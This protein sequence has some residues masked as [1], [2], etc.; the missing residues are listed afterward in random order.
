MEIWRSCTISGDLEEVP[1]IGPAAV[2]ILSVDDDVSDPINTTHQLFG[3]YL[4]LKGKEE[5]T[6]K[7]VSC[8]DHTERFW[9]FLKTKGISAHRSAIVKVSSEEQVMFAILLDDIAALF[10]HVSTNLFSP[11]VCRPLP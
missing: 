7:P 3:Q 10:G 2:A 11:T 4:L 1:G 9:Y 6:G 5:A 8:F